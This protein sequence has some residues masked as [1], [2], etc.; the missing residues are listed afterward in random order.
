M[1]VKELIE[2]LKKCNED[3]IVKDFYRIPTTK[4]IQDNTSKEIILSDRVPLGL[5]ATAK[6]IK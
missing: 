2:V 1:K 5:Y 4:V 3:F 6:E